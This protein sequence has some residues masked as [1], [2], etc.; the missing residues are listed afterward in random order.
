MFQFSQHWGN[1]QKFV[2]I[3][4]YSSMWDISL[5]WVDEEGGLV[6]RVGWTIAV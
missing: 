3:T 6:S 4:N 2:E 5:N 1:P